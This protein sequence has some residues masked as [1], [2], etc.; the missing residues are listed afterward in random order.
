MN[1]LKR[2]VRHV[3][4]GG[5]KRFATIDEIQMILQVMLRLEWT[6]DDIIS[7]IS[8]GE[9]QLLSEE[10]VSFYINN[11]YVNTN[12]PSHTKACEALGFKSEGRGTRFGYQL[13]NR[14]IWLLDTYFID[15]ELRKK[16]PVLKRNDQHRIAN[17]LIKDYLA[18]RIHID[19]VLSLN[20]T[21]IAM[22]LGISLEKYEGFAFDSETATKLT[23]I[24][25]EFPEVPEPKR[26]PNLELLD[27]MVWGNSVGVDP[28][29]PENDFYQ[30]V[31][32][33]KDEANASVQVIRPLP[34]YHDQTIMPMLHV[35][36][37][38]QNLRLF[39]Y[40]LSRDEFM[41]SVD[42][43]FDMDT[44][45]IRYIMGSRVDVD[46]SRKLVIDDEFF[47]VQA[48]RFSFPT[49]EKDPRRFSFIVT[50]FIELAMSLRLISRMY[51]VHMDDKGKIS[52]TKFKIS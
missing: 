4:H 9:K 19:D 47:A 34:P 32:F 24:L 48:G 29:N 7:K 13:L 43:L 49:F 39:I 12:Y 40:R 35:G 30:V 8:K 25:A 15:K 52:G 36:F 11:V 44:N 20:V 37:R 23:M 18:L 3:N 2:V 42:S 51:Q 1:V 46:D 22:T 10:N 33:I 5:R 50:D 6:M 27:P 21:S 28:H 38:E 45:V 26:K 31:Q 16:Y 14:A 17:R 41:I